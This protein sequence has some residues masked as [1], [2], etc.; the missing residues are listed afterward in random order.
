[1]KINPSLGNNVLTYSMQLPQV[2]LKVKEIK[3]RMGKVILYTNLTR[4]LLYAEASGYISLSLLKQDLAFV[5]DSDQSQTQP[6]IYLVNTA[7]IG[8][9][10]PLNLFYLNHLK[11]KNY[12]KHYIVYINF[13]FIC[14]INHSF[15]KLIS[16]DQIL[17]SE[18]ELLTILNDHA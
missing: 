9:A 3:T 14:F 7:Q 17:K 10:H 4:T 8:F 16:I 11:D 13:P 15:R 6:W 18:Q 5:S 1:M 12:L 2:Y